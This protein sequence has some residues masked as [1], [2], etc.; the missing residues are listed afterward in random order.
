MASIRKHGDGFQ[1]RYYTDGRQQCEQFATWEAADIRVKEIDLAKAKGV[2]VEAKPHSVK[3]GTLAAAV[4]AHYD[5]NE[6]RSR[7]D[8][9]CRYRL[10]LVPFFGSRKAVTITGA[11]I[12]AYV[13]IR[14]AEGAAA[15]SINRELEA[16][17]RAFR[18]GLEQGTVASAPRIKLLKESNSRTGFF[19]RLEVDRVCSHL[20]EPLNRFV[21]F[22]FLTAWRYDEIRN[23]KWSN[24]DFE[25]EEIRLEPGTTKNGEGRA[26]PMTAELREVIGTARTVTGQTEKAAKQNP[27]KLK[28]VATMTAFI[29]S[30]RGRQV[31]AFRKQWRNAC[32]KAGL[33]CVVGVDG[34]PIR[35]LR[36]FHDLRRSGVRELAKALGERRAMARSGHKTR[37]VFDRYNI[38]SDFDLAEDRRLLE[39]MATVKAK[40]SDSGS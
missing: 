12:N 14:K 35:S 39:N 20:R 10:H 8:I 40:M 29:F 32:F 9:E 24:V 27:V 2:T 26:F 5:V 23:L 33:P 11:N 36:L 4:V 7:D 18:L 21:L 13:N 15:G 16:M 28:R 6:L 38:V 31:G 30:I 34:K 1:V 19:T 3:F 22:A 25:R 17:K 37:S